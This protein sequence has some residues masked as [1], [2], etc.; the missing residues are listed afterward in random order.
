MLIP[1]RS[2]E[3]IPPDAVAS[4]GDSAAFR[5]QPHERVVADG[6]SAGVRSL[7]R[8]RTSKRTAFTS[9][10][11]LGLRRGFHLTVTGPYRRYPDVDRLGSVCVWRVSRPP[12]W[13]KRPG[14]SDFAGQRDGMNDPQNRPSPV[15]ATSPKSRG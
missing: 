14:S 7:N 4:V 1:G 3:D 8:C 2:N 5:R 15:S 11:L 12:Y 6:E 13:P 10:R 9:T